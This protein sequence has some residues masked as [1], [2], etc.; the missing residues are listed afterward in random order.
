[1]RPRPA[2]RRRNVSLSR[3]VYGSRVFSLE[4]KLLAFNITIQRD[5][6]VYRREIGKRN[7]KLHL[8]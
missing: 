4:N 7:V 2:L 3:S 8:Q 1:M 5:V 6:D